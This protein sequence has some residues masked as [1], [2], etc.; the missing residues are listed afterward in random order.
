[1]LH[2]LRYSFGGL[3]TLN[4]VMWGATGEL[5]SAGSGRSDMSTNE[6]RAARA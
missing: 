2:V 6:V 1:M 5:W 3:V 4:G